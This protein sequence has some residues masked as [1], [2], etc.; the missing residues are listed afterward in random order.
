MIKLLL[1][2]AATV[3]LTGCASGTCT[4]N[5]V[6]GFGPGNPH[7]EQLALHMDR[8]DPCQAGAT[9]ERRIELGRPVGYQR[10]SWCRGGSTPRRI[11]NS[12]GQFIG[13]V[14]R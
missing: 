14:S 2:L 11:Y 13:S 9:E 3:T 4:R 5:C 1:A 6:F 12:R 7:F 8:S 10:P